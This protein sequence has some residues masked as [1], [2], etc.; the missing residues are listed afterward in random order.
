MIHSSKTPLIANLKTSTEK[1]LLKQ[2]LTMRLFLSSLSNA[3]HYLACDA[4]I[5]ARHSPQTP[6]LPQ[7]SALH[8]PHLDIPQDHAFIATLY[9]APLHCTQS[10]HWVLAMYQPTSSHTL[11]VN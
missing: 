5:H 1:N 11:A 10:L 9:T 7:T 2:Y 3:S 4:W 8:I 6:L